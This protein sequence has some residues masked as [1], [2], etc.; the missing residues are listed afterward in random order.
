MLS[1]LQGSKLLPYCSK[2]RPISNPLYSA[3][4]ASCLGILLVC[5]SQTSR[6]CCL[7]LLL[8][9]PSPRVTASFRGSDAKSLTAVHQAH[10]G[11]T[12]SCVAP[13]PEIQHGGLLSKRGDQSEAKPALGVT[14]QVLSR[15]TW[16]RP[17]L[18]QWKPCRCESTRE[19]P[20]P[21][22]RETYSALIGSSEWP[23]SH[24]ALAWP[25]VC[26]HV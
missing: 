4:N 14:C 20:S 7:V 24:A 17:S 15:P 26:S 22:F 9:P 3:D 18:M 10:S 23:Q 11:R 16:P 21:P 6:A 19:G 5:S 8:W 25:L 13:R 1:Y 12:L 2:K